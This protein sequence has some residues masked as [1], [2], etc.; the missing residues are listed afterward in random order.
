MIKLIAILLSICLTVNNFAQDISSFFSKTNTL[1]E[2]YV[3]AGKVDYHNIKNESN[4]AELIDAIAKIDHTS[5][6][7]TTQKAFLIN[8]YNLLVIQQLTDN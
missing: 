5:L 7:K 3:S 2:Q 8:A 4:L 1:L 6:D